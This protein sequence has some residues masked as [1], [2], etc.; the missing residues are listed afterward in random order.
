MAIG[1]RRESQVTK[2]TNELRCIAASRARAS[3]LITEAGAHFVAEASTEEPPRR[4]FIPLYGHR[5]TCEGK[6][7][8]GKTP[9][10]EDDL[11]TIEK[12]SVTVADRVAISMAVEKEEIAAA[13][14]ILAF[15][16]RRLRNRPV[17]GFG[18]GTAS[19]NSTGVRTNAP[20]RSA[21][22]DAY[23]CDQGSGR[24]DAAI[25][26]LH[27]AV[28]FVVRR[29]PS[30]RSKT[31]SAKFTPSAS[32]HEHRPE[33]SKYSKSSRE[34]S[35]DTAKVRGRSKNN[36]DIDEISDTIVSDYT[37]EA[38][39]SSGVE[40]SPVPLRARA[41]SLYTLPA[42]L[43]IRGGGSGNHYTMCSDKTK[44]DRFTEINRDVATRLS[45]VR[46]V[47]GLRA[48][49][50][51]AAFA[52]PLTST[53]T[54]VPVPRLHTSTPPATGGCGSPPRTP[55]PDALRQRLNAEAKDAFSAGIGQPLGSTRR[56][57]FPVDHRPR[58]GLRRKV[59][60][61]RFNVQWDREQN[62]E[63]KIDTW[64]PVT[65]LGRRLLVKRAQ[66]L[67]EARKQ[68]MLGVMDVLRVRQ[69][70][71]QLRSGA[72]VNALDAVLHALDARDSKSQEERIPVT[73]MEELLGLVDRFVFSD[74]QV[75]CD[76][77]WVDHGAG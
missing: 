32:S 26:T 13:K 41:S 24:L 65:A 43:V 29:N 64:G 9:L 56:L 28:D 77:L 31:S 62:S 47:F 40:F 74:S 2:L 76:G 20:Y 52:P 46:S 17:K 57:Y 54:A 72:A 23:A 71:R 34:I 25:Y 16:R 69:A 70:G 18:A 5:Q 75:T 50:V 35:D 68:Q 10:I 37:N 59:Y 45:S 3:T 21:K 8:L 30:S 11:S 44:I 49:D 6:Q 27:E 66:A 39:H 12:K 58:L 55:S 61:R 48:S 1:F 63:R 53:S 22:T 36:N 38:P 67:T 33:Y 4:G 73:H 7:I 51:L 60:P 14:R 19:V 42:S 15:L